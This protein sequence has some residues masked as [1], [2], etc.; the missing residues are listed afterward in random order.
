M[1]KQENLEKY[2]ENRDL[3]EQ[4]FGENAT[5]YW[6]IYKYHYVDKISYDRI[7]KCYHYSATTV[8][9]IIHRIEEFLDNPEAAIA[10]LDYPIEALDGDIWMPKEFINGFYSLSICA[11]KIFCEAIYLYQHGMIQKIHKSHIL[12][13]AAQYRDS[14]RRATLC[15]ELRDFQIVLRDGR[16]IKIFESIEDD[17]GALR[18]EF[19]QEALNY[20]DPRYAFAKQIFGSGI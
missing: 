12:F 11:N 7:G 5:T 14:K 9:N 18:F 2:E 1:Y 16:C 8:R 19:S 17:R 10:E 3:F 4:F 15:D 6:E 13:C 20:I